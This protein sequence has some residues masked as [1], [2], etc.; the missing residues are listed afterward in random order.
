MRHPPRKVYSMD[1]AQ[2]TVQQQIPLAPQPPTSN[3]LSEDQVR[4]IK[5]WSSGALIPVFYTGFMRLWPLFILELIIW[6][7][8]PS[9][10][11][12]LILAL[13]SAGAGGLAGLLTWSILQ[14]LVFITSIIVFFTKVAKG[15]RL[16]WKS[17]QWESF[18]QFL[19]VQKKWDIWGRL[20]IIISLAT[21]LI[22]VVGI[23]VFTFRFA[24]GSI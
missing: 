9:L 22:G 6:L 15:K 5:S 2:V 20:L 3:T 11:P 24:L 1:P 18:D 16:A 17:R 19:I 21:V 12:S 10:I 8:L 14:G 7:V 4:I 23:T 13:L